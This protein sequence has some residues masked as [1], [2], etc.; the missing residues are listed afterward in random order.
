[1]PAYVAQR[2]SEVLNSAGKATRGS[3]IL[4]LGLAYKPGVNDVR[5]SPA[6][7]VLEHLIAAGADCTYHD[8]FVPNVVIRPKYSARCA[9]ESSP[10][11]MLRS[12]EIN[13]EI[14]RTADCVVILTPH[15]D[16]DFPSVV[17]DASLVFDAAGVTRDER[18][19][20]VVLL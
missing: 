10:E 9:P 17:A 2:V 8:A 1:M 7:E 5:E 4:V 13:P 14:I 15:P 18:A 20:N 11:I 3:R 12:S 19:P 16:I 6:V